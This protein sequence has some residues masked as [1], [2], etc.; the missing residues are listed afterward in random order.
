MT[1][2]SKIMKAILNSCSLTLAMN[3]FDPTIKKFLG[4]TFVDPLAINKGKSQTI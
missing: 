3:I 2:A 1:D 4:G